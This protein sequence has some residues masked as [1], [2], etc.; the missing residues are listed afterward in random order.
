MQP[1]P[2]KNKLALLTRSSKRNEQIESH[3]LQR[4]LECMRPSLLSSILLGQQ[5]RHSF[6]AIKNGIPPQDLLLQ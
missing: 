2:V 1:Y 6:G 5:L 4:S 3:Y